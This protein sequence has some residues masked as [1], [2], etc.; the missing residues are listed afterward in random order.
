[1]V[2]IEAQGSVSQI[3]K[4]APRPCIKCCVKTVSAMGLKL[5]FI[6]LHMQK[7]NAIFKIKWVHNRSVP[8]SIVRMFIFM[9]RM[10]LMQVAHA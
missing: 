7:I 6:R 1:M 10:H 9:F 5:G 8:C 2:E 4:R 3:N